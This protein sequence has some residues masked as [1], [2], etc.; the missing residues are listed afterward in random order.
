MVMRLPDS[1]RK[2]P[3]SE[4]AKYRNISAMV[5]SLVLKPWPLHPRRAPIRAIVLESDSEMGILT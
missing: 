4:S 1:S 5:V 3:I 2:N